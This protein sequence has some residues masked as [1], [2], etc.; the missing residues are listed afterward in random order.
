MQP[1]THWQ[2]G[3]RRKIAL[4]VVLTLVLSSLGVTAYLV[5]SQEYESDVI[6]MSISVT[7]IGSD[8]IHVLGIFEPFDEE[9][10][11]QSLLC[12]PIVGGLNPLYSETNQSAY[13]TSFRTTLSLNIY[14]NFVIGTDYQ[15]TFRFLDESNRVKTVQ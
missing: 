2:A 7:A 14:G 3:P 10:Q 4:S 1:G 5:S 11:L 8:F 12:E 13:T 15:F 6:L 9:L